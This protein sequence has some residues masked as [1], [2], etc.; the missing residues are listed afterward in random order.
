[1]YK[2][3]EFKL[4]PWLGQSTAISSEPAKMNFVEKQ[5]TLT[6]LMMKP[7]ATCTVQR[8]LFLP[9]KRLKETAVY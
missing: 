5:Y 8:A 6:C 3:L 1:M 4:T 7:I 9:L 2:L